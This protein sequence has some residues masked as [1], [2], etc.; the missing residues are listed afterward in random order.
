[1]AAKALPIPIMSR[2]FSMSM[3]WKQQ[4]LQGRKG[5]KTQW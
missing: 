2:L 3:F 5:L 1:M 4:S